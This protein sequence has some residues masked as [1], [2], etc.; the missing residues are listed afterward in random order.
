MP[1]A[2][3]FLLQIGIVLV[4]ANA[5]I[6]S[7]VASTVPFYYWAV[8]AILVQGKVTGPELTDAY[9]NG[10]YTDYGAVTWVAMIAVIHNLAYCAI[11]F[12]LFPTETGFL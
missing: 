8:A 12:Y 6:N 2:W 1:H 11:N 3:Y 10:N 4:F 5:E 9:T 7:R